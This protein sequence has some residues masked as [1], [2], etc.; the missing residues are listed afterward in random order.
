M[1]IA[2]LAALLPAWGTALDLIPVAQAEVNHQRQEKLASKLH[3]EALGQAEIFHN[4]A[5][6]QTKSFH[7]QTVAQTIEFHRQSIRQAKRIYSKQRMYDER[8]AAR[9]ARRDI[10]DQK[11]EKT[12]T[13]MV[14]NTLMFGCCFAII[15]EGMPPT[16][17]PGEWIALFACSLGLSFCSLFLSIIFGLSLQSTMSQYRIDRIGQRYS[18]GEHHFNFNEFWYCHCSE[19]SDYATWS[20]F[21]GTC[22]LAFTAALL[23]LLR[24]IYV[25]GSRA[26]A[27]ILVVELVFAGILLLVGHKVYFRHNIVPKY[28]QS[29]PSDRSAE[30]EL[31]TEFQHHQSHVSIDVRPAVND[32]APPPLRRGRSSRIRQPSPRLHQGALSLQRSSSHRAGLAV[33][34]N[35]SSSSDGSIDMPAEALEVPS[36]SARSNVRSSPNFASGASSTMTSPF[37]TPIVARGSRRQQ[38]RKV[39][40]P[41]Q[42]VSPSKR[43]LEG[44]PS[45]RSRPAR[46]DRKKEP[47][48]PP[49]LVVVPPSSR[50]KVGSTEVPSSVELAQEGARPP[51]APPQPAAMSPQKRVPQAETAVAETSDAEQE[52]EEVDAP[53]AEEPQTLLLPTPSTDSGTGF[54]RLTS[55][56]RRFE[57]QVSSSSRRTASP[58]VSSSPYVR[59]DEDKAAQR[60]PAKAVD[61]SVARSSSDEP[62]LPYPR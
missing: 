1:S 6:E 56:S 57:R 35:S 10:W 36:L 50:K 34:S 2:H 61:K 11:T 59:L 43:E 33:L 55:L 4:Q 51:A 32:P 37:A 7:E 20:F 5:I 38:E 41:A 28:E 21:A 29:I 14:L 62:M 42:A 9:E 46:T 27:C 39:R 3:S 8:L 53:N 40:T 19:L 58:Q 24:F 60:Q 16:P 45:A 47:V 54:Q 52:D 23:L 44:S 31:D 13:L 12:G 22:F 25:F 17:L 18:C 49:E 26:S 30:S 15:V 48:R